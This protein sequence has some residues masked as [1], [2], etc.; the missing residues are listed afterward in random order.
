MTDC[1][2]INLVYEVAVIVDRVNEQIGVDV[3]ASLE[4]ADDGF[5]DRRI[6]PGH[7]RRGCHSDAVFLRVRMAYRREVH[8]AR[9]VTALIHIGSPTVRIC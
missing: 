3:A 7:V 1:V 9:S 5:L 8:D 2:T 6:R 4:L